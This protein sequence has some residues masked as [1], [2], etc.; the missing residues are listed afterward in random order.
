VFD[1]AAKRP[2]KRLYDRRAEMLSAMAGAYRKSVGAEKVT[3][4]RKVTRYKPGRS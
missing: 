3:Q 2:L 1:R 4:K